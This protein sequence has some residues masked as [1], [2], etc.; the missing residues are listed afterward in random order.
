MSPEL[1]ANLVNK[2]PTLFKDINRPPTESLI[3][4]GCS[5]GDG[6]YDLLDRT[7]KKIIDNDPAREIVLM[8]VKEKFGELRIYLYCP[9][10]IQSKIYE[11]LGKAELES[12]T[13]CEN[14][15]SIENIKSNGSWI[16]YLCKDCIERR[17][18]NEN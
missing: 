8:Q 18:T 14:C 5:C 11:I 1:E 10:G 9:T 4:F 3:C 16:K 12:R 15:G 2:Y 7:F 13:I 6:W 17:Y